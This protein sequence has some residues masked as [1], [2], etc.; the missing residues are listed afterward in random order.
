MLNNMARAHLAFLPTPLH[1]LERLSRA[2]HGPRLW[3]KRDDLTGLALGGNKARKL[4]YLM[5]DALGHQATTVI[6]AGA[7]QSNHARQTAAAAAHY[8]LRCILVLSGI[9]P[10]TR[11]GNLLLD[12]LFGAHL[13]W[14]GDR[15]LYTVMEEAAQEEQAAGRIPYL[16]PVG[17][18]NAIGASAYVVAMQEM[19]RQM[20]QMSLDIDHI[21]VASGSG[22][23]QAGLV[24]GA[25]AV[26][27]AGRITG[28]SVS[29]PADILGTRILELARLTAGYLDLRFDIA[30]DDVKVQDAYLGAGYGM[31]GDAEREAITLLARTEGLLL[32]PVY[33][34]R[35]MA[36]LLDMIRRG[37]VSRRE[38]V[39]F[40]HTGGSPAL[41]AYGD[42]IIMRS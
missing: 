9:A 33:T 30:L 19:A 16:I 37:E 4:E 35:A 27:F 41:F 36:G 29:Q 38:S 20:A 23:T 22:G 3:V 13:R 17:G 12:G 39:L 6:T 5:A 26:N 14:A 28:V 34:G 8:G 25:R 24:V 18:S 32:D 7:A 31:M 10:L 15:D 42:Q 2:L 40:W 11:S 21:F 1:S